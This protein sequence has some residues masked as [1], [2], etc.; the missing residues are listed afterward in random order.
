MRKNTLLIGVIWIVLTIL[1][2][3][4]YGI[5]NQVLDV[6]ENGFDLF[7]TTISILPLFISLAITYVFVQVLALRQLV[8]TLCLITLILILA[9]PASLSLNR[10]LD[11]QLKKVDPIGQQALAASFNKQIDSVRGSGETT[12]M[13]VK[14]LTNFAW[15]KLFLFG[16]Y[17]THT[18]IN[19]RLGY[20]WTRNS[21]RLSDDNLYLLIFTLDGKVVQYLDQTSPILGDLNKIY[22]PDGGDI[23][24][25]NSITDTNERSQP[26]MQFIER[27]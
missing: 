8:K 11:Q 13:S 14:E 21:L 16:P 7:N 1:Y 15:D 24:F 20:T 25:I 10:L 17:T 26:H 19:E 23:Q 4:A 27:K 18:Q 22:T 3:F 5:V 12:A 2:Y 9:V 6:R